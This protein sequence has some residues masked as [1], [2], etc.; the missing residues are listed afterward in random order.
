MKVASLLLLNFPQALKTEFDALPT[1]NLIYAI[2]WKKFITTL[3][4]QWKESL[5]MVSS[6]P[7]YWLLLSFLIIASWV[8]YWSPHVRM[9]CLSPILA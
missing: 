1:D 2:H 9:M 3:K 5:M 4:E 6:L 8:V 7:D